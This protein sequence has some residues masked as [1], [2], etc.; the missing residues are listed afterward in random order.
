M[1]PCKVFKMEEK[2]LIYHMVPFSYLSQTT[3]SAF[4]STFVQKEEKC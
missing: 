3:F 4:L 1:T 2:D